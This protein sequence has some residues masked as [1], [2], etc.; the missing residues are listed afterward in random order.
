[1]SAKFTHL[2]LKSATNNLLDNFK[3]V[4]GKK[5]LFR[6]NYINYLVKINC[7]TAVLSL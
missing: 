4:Y 2:S 7:I 5:K 3:I 6:K 1:M